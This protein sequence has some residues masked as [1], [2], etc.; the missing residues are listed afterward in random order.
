[1][2]VGDKVIWSSQSQGSRTAKEGVIVEVVP[3]EWYPSKDIS[4]KLW[5]SARFTKGRN[6][7]SY[8]VRVK[9]G[10]RKP[11]DYWP[12]AKSLCLVE[13]ETVVVGWRDI[14]TA[15]KDETVV[16]LWNRRGWHPIC[17]FFHS[18][19]F[20]LYE[21]LWRGLDGAPTHWMP[22]PDPPKESK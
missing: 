21:G 7:E 18:K 1:M 10:N 16:Q 11:V 12:L 13:P 20:D 4:P 8:V 3:E 2:K 14:S 17:K 5:E 22:L 19:W 6:H 9:Y 15:P